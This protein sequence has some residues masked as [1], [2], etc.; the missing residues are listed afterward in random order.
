MLSRE[1]RL[2]LLGKGSAEAV[3]IAYENKATPQI[4]CF[5]NK[6]SD[7]SQ[8]FLK[9]ISTASA[10]PSPRAGAGPSLTRLAGERRKRKKRKKRV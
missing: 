9:A 4:F 7:A 8:S 3:D 6:I 10:S 2:F 5:T 1:R